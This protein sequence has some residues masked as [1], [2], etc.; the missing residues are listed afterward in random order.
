MQPERLQHWPQGTARST[1]QGQPLA[2]EHERRVVTTAAPAVRIKRCTQALLQQL[3][4][5]ATLNR[6]RKSSAPR[7]CQTLVLD[8][9]TNNNTNNATKNNTATQQ[10]QQP[11]HASK[12][13]AERKHTQT[14]YE[15]IAYRCRYVKA[16]GTEHGGATRQQPPLLA[17]RTQH[18]S[19]ADVTFTVLDE[20]HLLCTHGQR[21]TLS[22]RHNREHPQR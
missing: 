7:D 6:K 2:G 4:C 19:R 16:A 22:Q 21:T 9:N 5:E 12:H 20:P 15:C 13:G 11:Q 10:P 18:R 1:R 8:S 14:Q 3:Q 17:D